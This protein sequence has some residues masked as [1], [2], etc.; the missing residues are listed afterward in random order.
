MGLPT[1]FEKGAK[2]S[3]VSEKNFRINWD[4]MVNCK[5]SVLRICKLWLQKNCEKLDTMK[6]FKVKKLKNISAEVKD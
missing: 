2:P 4:A 6:L 1:H 5:S 3:I